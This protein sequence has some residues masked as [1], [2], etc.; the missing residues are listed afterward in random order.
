MTLKATLTSGKLA[1]FYDESM[2]NSNSLTPSIKL[3][4]AMKNTVCGAILLI[5]PVT[6]PV[7]PSTYP[8]KFQSLLKEFAD[9]FSEPTGLPP[10]R[11]CD[12][13]IPFQPD[14]KIIN[15]RSYRLPHHQKNAVEEIIQSLLKSSII[16]LSVSP[17]S[18]PAIMVK[19]KD[20]SW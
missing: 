8:P 7:P 11:D 10:Q 9:I 13:A 4:K 3:H 14:A 19:K 16:W 5:K 18:S 12:H 20:N 1:I 15:Q 2:P 6:E 17:Y